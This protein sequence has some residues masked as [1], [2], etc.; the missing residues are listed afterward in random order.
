MLNRQVSE[1][2]GSL[3]PNAISRTSLA[4]ATTIV[5]GTALSGVISSQLF[6]GGAVIVPSTWTA[7]NIGFKVCDTPAGTFVPFRDQ[8]GGLVQIT[9][10]IANAANAYPLPDALFGSLF[11]KL[12]SCDA[13][14]ADV[15]QGADRVITVILKG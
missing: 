5:S 14:G 6:P 10:V 4:V 8:Y 11:I 2:S 9:G 13:A 15:N 3:I 1:T 7:A 12:W